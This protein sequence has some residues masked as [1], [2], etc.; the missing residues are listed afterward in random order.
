MVAFVTELL[1]LF[2]AHCLA[3]IGLHDL[4]TV[5]FHR[6]LRHA[7]DVHQHL[8]DLGVPLSSDIIGGTEWLGHLSHLELFLLLVGLHIMR[9]FALVTLEERLLG[10]QLLDADRDLAQVVVALA[11]LERREDHRLHSLWTTLV[12]PTLEVSV[13]IAFVFFLL[14]NGFVV[15]IIIYANVFFFVGGDIFVI[16]V[17]VKVHPP[18]GPQKISLLF[19]FL[20]VAHD[21]SILQKLFLALFIND[22]LVR[23]LAVLASQLVEVLVLLGVCHVSSHL[24]LHVLVR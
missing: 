15:I 3:A 23:L 10:A 5:R 16:I 14:L 12:I 13:T 24:L 11:R 4:L 20:E 2:G 6:L 21:C 17:R 22:M 7:R 19:F 1:A 8:L 9:Q 18:L